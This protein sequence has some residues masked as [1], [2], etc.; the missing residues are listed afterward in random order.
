MSRAQREEED[1]D[2]C[3]QDSL[4]RLLSSADTS[5]SST[6]PSGD[7]EDPISRLASPDPFCQPGFGPPHCAY[8]VW[9]SRP[10]SVRERR[11]RLLRLLGLDCDSSLLRDRTSPSPAVDCNAG[12]DTG[13]TGGSPSSDHMKCLTGV[14]EEGFSNTVDNCN[15]GSTSEFSSVSGIVRS[16]S[17]GCCNSPSHSTCSSSLVHQNSEIL[18]VDSVSLSPAPGST[19]DGGSISVNNSQYRSRSASNIDRLKNCNGSPHTNSVSPNKPPIAKYKGESLHNG[20]SNGVVLGVEETVCTIKDLDNGKEFVV[21]EV[22]EDG[23]WNKLKEVGTG[24][25][26][27][28]EE[29][30]MCVGTSPIVQELMRRQSVEDRNKDGLDSNANDSGGSGSKLKKKGGWLKSIRNVANSVTGHK[31]RRSSD[32][33]DTSSEKGGR[34]S[35]SATDDSQDASFHGPERVRVR[36]YGKTCKEFSALYK[37]QEIQAHNGSIWS[38]KF[39]LDG[40]YLASAGED[41]VIHVWQV[42]ENK[43][44]L[45]LDKPDDGSLNILLH[46]NGSSE[47]NSASPNLDGYTEKKKRGKSYMSRKSVSFDHVYVPKTVFALSE[48]TICTL[49][50][51]ADA[52][53]DLSWSKSQCLLSSS[54]DK[55]VRLWD[56]SSKSCLKIFSH[57]DYVTCIQFNPVDDRFFI[58]GS[59]DAKVR[60]WSIPD[61]QVVDWS[62]L[63]E[64]VT[65]ACYTPD[66]QGALVGSYKGSCHMYDTSENKLQQKGQIHLQIKKK[67]SHQKKITGFEFVPGS[68]SKVLVT[69]ADSRIRVIEDVDLVQKFKGFHNSSSQISASISAD[70][71]YVVCASEDSYV[72]V[73]KHED[74]SQPGRIKGVTLTQSYEQFHCQDVSVAIPWPRTGEPLRSQDNISSAEHSGPLDLTD[75]VSAANHHPTSPV[76]ET[77]GNQRSR[78]PSHGT[79]SSATD[80]YFLDKISAAWLDEKHTPITASID[81][82]NG[83]LNQT[84][85][86]GL[87][88][89]IVTAG[90]RGVI[91]TFQNFGMPIRI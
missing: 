16:R 37:T 62:D 80:S 83:L 56:L 26:L 53:L 31:D 29:F 74:D 2:E 13:S 45:L 28:M 24:R 61:R 23:M 50:G 10:C 60:I 59:L 18:S 41:C 1:E 36:Q 54:M 34:R 73:W 20:S 69:S 35:S 76:E 87:G 55:T 48:K 19:N 7:E 88:L 85:P 44:D 63:H 25:Q 46:A 58:S 4:D 47:P 71:R 77:C 21:N 42:T 38:I 86:A 15:S 57:S 14:R 9:I 65:A 32:E 27:T 8:D 30:E 6:S 82:P 78:S 5:C 40:N 43:G 75:E 79:I 33:R 52:V 3:F 64:M 12:E 81:L 91:R 67:K 49:H 89:V 70:G 84:K 72:Y 51:H 66:G 17:T 11:T 90:A 39:S 22:R 68:T